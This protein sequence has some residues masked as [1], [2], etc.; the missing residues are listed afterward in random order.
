MAEHRRD[1]M[2]ISGLSMDLTDRPGRQDG[3]I[4]DASEAAVNLQA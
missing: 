4:F 1:C 2:L 3:S